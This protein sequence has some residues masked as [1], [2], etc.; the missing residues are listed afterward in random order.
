M[1]YLEN[2]IGVPQDIMI[3]KE[4]STKKTNKAVT[5]QQARE[6]SKEEAKAA[7][8]AQQFKTINDED[9][10]GT[11]N[12][13]VKAGVTSVNGQ[14]GDLKL[15]TINN[16][17]LLGEGNIEIQGGGG[18]TDFSYFYIDAADFKLPVIDGLIE[19]PFEKVHYYGAAPYYYGCITIKDV[20]G[21]MVTIPINFGSSGNTS[22]Y[23]IYERYTYNID[24]SEKWGITIM[25][26]I[27]IDTTVP[28]CHLTGYFADHQ[29]LSIDD[30]PTTVGVSTIKLIGSV[31]FGGDVDHYEIAKMEFKGNGRGPY[32]YYYVD[33]NIYGQVTKNGTDP[34]TVR[35][36]CEKGYY[37][38]VYDRAGET[39]IFTCIKVWGGGAGPVTPVTSVNGQTGDVYIDVPTKVSE[40]ENDSKYI[41]NSN[42]V[43]GVNKMWTGS[44]AEYDAIENKDSGTLYIIL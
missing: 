8:E 7:V 21:N 25:T 30:L 33:G 10:R 1:I 44:Q 32:N 31:S 38:A 15:K 26:D 3:V 19:I 41:A 39:L 18:T 11:G 12:I 16:N 22:A 29:I 14:S 20:S 35:F 34:I 13:E 17:D 24:I 36:G 5:E 42:T 9:I 37:E 27:S 23:F 43:G 40:L 28:I 6:I 2:K 4:V